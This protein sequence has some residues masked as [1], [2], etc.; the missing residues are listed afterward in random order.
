[1]AEN[2]CVAAS[3][4]GD[5]EIGTGDFLVCRIKCALTNKR[6]KSILPYQVPYSV[7]PDLGSLVDN[8]YVG[9]KTDP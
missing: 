4:K 7:Q 1:M 6:D 2:S 5:S 8:D 3:R 9:S